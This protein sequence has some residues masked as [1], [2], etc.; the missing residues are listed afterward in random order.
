MT[1]DFSKLLNY[2]DD[3]EKKNNRYKQNK[4]QKKKIIKIK[5]EKSSI[6]NLLEDI[7]TKE[8]KYKKNSI[9]YET[10]SIGFNVTRFENLMKSRLIDN[11]KRL[12]SYDRPYISVN[13]LSTGAILR[14]SSCIDSIGI[15][16]NTSL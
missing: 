5:K 6:E 9:V 10:K 7:K 15:V 2:L 14:N 16:I 11:A 1:S 13:E 3:Q 4:P 12:T 8:I